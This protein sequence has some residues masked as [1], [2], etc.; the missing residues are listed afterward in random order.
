ME[1]ES[2]EIP[3]QHIV[4]QSF[5]WWSKRVYKKP[6]LTEK[7]GREDNREKG[8]TSLDRVSEWN[9]HFPKTH[10]SKKV[11]Q[12]VNNGQWQNCCELS[13]GCSKN[14]NHLKAKSLQQTQ[15]L[16]T[17]TI[18]TRRYL[19]TGDFW[20]LVEIQTPHEQNKN[21]PDSKLYSSNSSRVREHLQHLWIT[22]THS[23]S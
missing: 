9:S 18:Q 2:K 3:I 14:K 13:V 17:D 10:I 16:D 22:I 23:F 6:Y 4:V 5:K 11:T 8:L 20:L 1:K 21:S 7:H 19:C 15:L 12:S